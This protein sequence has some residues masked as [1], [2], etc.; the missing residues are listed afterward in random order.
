[1]NRIGT[2]PKPDILVV[3]DDPV[4]RKLIKIAFEQAGGLLNLHFCEDAVSALDFL[5]KS[6]SYADSPTPKACLIDIN[7]PGMSGIELLS[8]MKY[9]DEL[10][11]IPVTMFSSSDQHKDVNTCY[12]GQACGYV[13]KP[14]NNDEMNKIAQTL[15]RYW[16]E[17]LT[18]PQ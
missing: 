15:S 5:N 1:M 13:K 4:D 7:M 8:L 6:G 16:T 10:N 14:D 18:L 3:D 12:E 11:Y 17:I 2:S 9:S